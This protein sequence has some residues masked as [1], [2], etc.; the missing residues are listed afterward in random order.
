VKEEMYKLMVCFINTRTT[1][2]LA[3]HANHSPSRGRRR[4]RQGAPNVSG[5]N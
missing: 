3:R 1:Y 2:T 5:V 4:A